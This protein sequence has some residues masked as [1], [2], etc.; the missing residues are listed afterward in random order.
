MVFSFP[1]SRRLDKEALCQSHLFYSASVTAAAAVR[2]LL[3]DGLNVKGVSDAMRNEE[4][5]KRITNLIIQLGIK[6]KTVRVVC[7]CV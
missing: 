7:V 1:S 2:S 6:K 5:N 3:R 4:R